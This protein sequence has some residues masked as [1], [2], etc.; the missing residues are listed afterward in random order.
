M[1]AICIALLSFLPV[2]AVSA[3][4][5]PSVGL[6]SPAAGSVAYVASDSVELSVALS[7][8]TTPI[9]RVE[10]Y[11]GASRVAYNDTG[12]FT[13][14]TSVLWVAPAPKTYTLTAQVVDVNG[15]VTTSPAAATLTVFSH[16]GS[17]K[18]T[19]A[20]AT[21]I[22]TQV[23]SFANL[24]TLQASVLNF[25]GKVV[26]LQGR[27]SA[28]DGGEGWFYGVS[29]LSGSTD[30]MLVINNTVHR[31]ERLHPGE[32]DMRVAGAKGDNSVDDRE[33][34]Q[35]VLDTRFNVKGHSSGDVYLVGTNTTRLSANG[36]RTALIM[37]SGQHIDLNGATIKLGNWE[38]SSV[39]MN[40][41]LYD[42]PATARTGATGS[43]FGPGNLD[44]TDDGIADGLDDCLGISHGTID[45]NQSQQRLTGID[46]SHKFAP[47]IQLGNV[48]RLALLHLTIENFYGGG[49]YFNG[50]DAI[51]VNTDIVMDDITIDGGVGQGISIRGTRVHG[52][53]FHISGTRLFAANPPP[54]SVNANSITIWSNDSDYGLIEADDCD[55]GFKLQDGSTN[56]NFDTIKVTGTRV[57]QAVKFQGSTVYNGQATVQHIIAHDNQKNGLYIIHQLYLEIGSYEGARNG[58]GYVSGDAQNYRDIWIRDSTVAFGSIAVATPTRGVL[59]SRQ[60]ITALNTGTDR[61]ILGNVT[62]DS[63]P[64]DDNLFYIEGDLIGADYIG[65]TNASAPFQSHLINHSGDGA[66]STAP[67]TT[68]LLH[69][70]KLVSNQPMLAVPSPVRPFQVGG[71]D[72]THTYLTVDCAKVGESAGWVSATNVTLTSAPQCE[73]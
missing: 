47:T 2:F 26:Y 34:I 22:E 33:K 43:G 56:N 37:Y 46:S 65:I 52:D 49:I 12:P 60:P 3:W 66:M 6:N 54:W 57:E 70:S 11:D 30:D 17:Q 36:Y 45:G 58:L 9:K 16:R 24:A 8:F 25:A 21:P 68:A 71:S 73:E 7:G 18:A 20:L 41:A 53:N 28:G 39:V 23:A 50:I 5:V 55:W 4:A 31:F 69:V 32:L 51:D 10:F 72:L 1:K 62:I 64:A 67:D 63:P 42:A 61:R 29:G 27:N 35:K 44:C 15:V 14:T 19:G 40:E 48:K 38:N 59:D 13:A